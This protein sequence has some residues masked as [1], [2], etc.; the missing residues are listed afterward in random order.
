[1]ALNLPTGIAQ[2]ILGNIPSFIMFG[3]GL[4]IGSKSNYDDDQIISHFSWNEGVLWQ[5]KVFLQFL[6]GNGTMHC[7]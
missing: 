5:L 1:M 3:T 2:S 7:I 6:L 4:V